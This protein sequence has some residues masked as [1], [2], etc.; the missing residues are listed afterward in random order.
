M[1]TVAKRKAKTITIDQLTEL[2]Q[3]GCNYYDAREVD[4]MR[5]HAGDREELRVAQEYFRGKRHGMDDLL[6]AAERLAK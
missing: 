2:M 4:Q 6:M 5:I 3:K 1:L